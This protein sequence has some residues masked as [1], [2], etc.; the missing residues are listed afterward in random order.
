MNEDR[1]LVGIDVGSGSVSVV[2][3]SIE[4]DQLV[5]HGCGQ[6]RHDGARKGVIAKLDEVTEAIR[7][8][9]EEAEAMASVPVIA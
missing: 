1:P 7:I 4:D 6:A 3:G 2:V 5:V 8:A 9:A